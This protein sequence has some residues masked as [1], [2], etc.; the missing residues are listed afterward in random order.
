M[1]KLLLL[2]TSLCLAASAM[3]AEQRGGTIKQTTIKYNVPTCEN[4][5]TTAYE[6]TIRPKRAPVAQP[7]PCSACA[8]AAPAAPCA[9]AD[10]TCANKNLGIAN[11]VF[12]V[13][14]GQVSL[15]TTGNLWKQPKGAY[16][17]KGE[18]N[19]EFRGYDVQEDIYYGLYDRLALH[20][21]AGYTFQAPKTS[22]WKAEKPSPVRHTSTYSGT[23]GLAYH[24]ID[25]CPFDL[26]VGVDGT[27]GRVNT[28][29]QGFYY[30]NHAPG[31]IKDF[32]EKYTR[33]TPRAVAGFHIGYVTPYLWGAYS[34]AHSKA[35]GLDEDF[36]HVAP[37]VYIQPSKYWAVD[38]NAE[39]FRHDKWQYKAGLDL[40]PYKNMAV[41]L[42]VFAKEP[43]DDPMYTYGAAARLKF[44][45]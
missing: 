5:K 30:A 11:P 40:Y 44:V 39:K 41:G 17:E 45:F 6:E 29:K 22:Q 37:G 20:L 25:T 7:A 8:A 34:F 26:I 15:D 10:N 31:V 18:K 38:L 9:K 16:A 21:N 43:F 24:L 28:S 36:Y 14:R 3:A 33:I 35:K 4:C 42:Q 23:V 19:G 27:W 2:A 12:F 13:K 32:S 1:K